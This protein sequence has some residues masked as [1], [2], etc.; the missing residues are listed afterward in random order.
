MWRTRVGYAGGTT[1][2]P[3][4]RRIGDHTE[5]FQVD[6]DP[7]RLPYEDLLEAFWVVHSPFHPAHS[8]QYASLV[9]A[10]DDAQHE[11]ALASCKRIAS[12]TNRAIQTDVRRL[13]RFYVAEDYHQ[14]YGLRADKTLMADLGRY[15]L[16]DATLRES[17]T[18]AR[19]NGYAYGAGSSA[20][21]EREIDILGLSDQGVR[22]LRGVVRA[23]R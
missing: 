7:E 4:Y 12:K 17:T 14:K 19:L 3:T 22:H 6:F 18:A 11:A 16:D 1:A 10:H 20:R 15:Y 2:D 13:D 23:A 9:L 8:L 5:C 21:L